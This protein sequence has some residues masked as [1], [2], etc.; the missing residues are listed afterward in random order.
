VTPLQKA[1]RDIQVKME[2]EQRPVLARCRTDREHSECI[3]AYADITWKM[4]DAVSQQH[5]MAPMLWRA[6]R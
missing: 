4:I 2:M 3:S 5:G 6:I 1:V